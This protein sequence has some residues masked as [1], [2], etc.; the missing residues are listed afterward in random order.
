M[1]GGMA[2]ILTGLTQAL[3]P[4]VVDAIGRT[5]G[6]EREHVS[7]GMGV[8]VPIVVTALANKSTVADDLDTLMHVLPRDGPASLSAKVTDL[9]GADGAAA[10][11]R[12]WLFGTG[13]AAVGGTIDRSLGFN[14]SALL[15][16]AGPL[17]LGVVAQIAYEKRGD[18]DGVGHMLLLDSVEFQKSG[19][20]RV[21]QVREALDAGRQAAATVSPRYGAN[22]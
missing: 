16:I 18:P 2:A 4:D 8:V 22:G 6:L 14:A 20:E 13:A 15:D 3:S 19:G 5:T 7:K 9:P 10:T 12:S 11:V 17:V 21:R 1:E